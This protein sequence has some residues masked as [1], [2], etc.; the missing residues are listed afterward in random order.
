M[1]DKDHRMDER[2][3]LPFS[4]LTKTCRSKEIMLTAMETA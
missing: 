4:D 3:Q 1:V 2:H